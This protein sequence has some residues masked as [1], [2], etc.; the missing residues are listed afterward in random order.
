MAKRKKEADLLLIDD[1]D[2]GFRVKIKLGDF[3]VLKKYKL[4]KL[5]NPDLFRQYQ[6]ALVQQA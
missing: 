3:D 1:E 5:A 2:D 4:D 6:E